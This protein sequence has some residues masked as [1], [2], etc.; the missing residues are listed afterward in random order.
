MAALLS[1]W[2]GELLEASVNRFVAKKRQS[3]KA[4]ESFFNPFSRFKLFTL[5]WAT[6]GLM[7]ISPYI[8]DLRAAVGIR[9]L[10]IP[11][12][13]GIIRDG[14]QILLVQEREGGRW[15]T[16]GGALELDDTPAN[17]VIREVYEETGLT[18]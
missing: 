9:R 7:P 13:A 16:P 8:R 4:G 14:E 1:L 6:F 3:A 11:T 17:A 15:S 10:L 5:D 2:S 18:V 12:V